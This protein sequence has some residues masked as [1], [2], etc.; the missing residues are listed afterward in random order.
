MINKEINFCK[1]CLYGDT[2]PLGLTIDS[3]GLCSGCQIHKEKYNLDWK[4]RFEK[5]KKITKEY[6]SLNK[7]NYDCI[8]P[9]S[10]G[11]ESYWTVHVVK[12]LLGMNPLLVSYNKYYN[13][14]LGIRNLSN[15]RIQF[16]CDF[17]LMNIDPRKIKKITKTT[18]R[19]FGSIYWHCIAGQ[20]VFP[21]QTAR[22]LK[23]PLIIWGSHQ[24]IEQVGMFSHKHEVEMTRRYR[25]D[26]DLMGYEAE[27]LITPENSL[28]EDDI[29]QFIYPDD[30][31][32]HKIGIRGIYLSNYIPWD[33]KK[34]DEEMIKIC[35]F[36][37]TSH[38]KTFDTYEHVD[39]FNYMNIHDQLKLYK[40]GY[41]KVTDHASRE[42]R[43]QR[44]NRDDAEVL[45]KHYEK[46]KINYTNYFNEWLN[47]KIDSL[48]TLLDLQ[49]NKSFW[50]LNDWNKK[51]WDFFGWSKIRKKNKNKKKIYDI[52]KKLNFISNSTFEKKLKK[53]ITI[54]KGYP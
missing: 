33:P 2:H 30:L 36:K 27:D 16:D 21:V 17:L 52:E 28:D 44:L 31:D 10:G 37:S 43:H 51:T 12:N 45:V 18:L 38:K 9:V 23:V 11:S 29:W 5:L 39:C 32:I 49:K 13:T 34:Q 4:Y 35:K 48:N 1:N 54:G 8:V 47:I 41:S 7:K 46:N 26:H 14:E 40:H 53:Y 6:K 22:D 20:T 3:S 15:L 19:M 50:K 25:K 42:I 24:G